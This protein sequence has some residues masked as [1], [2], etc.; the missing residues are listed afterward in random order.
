MVFPA[1]F[2]RQSAWLRVE[3]LHT[4]SCS[5]C[6]ILV[7]ICA[8]FRALNARDLNCPRQYLLSSY[9]TRSRHSAQYLHAA[10]CCAILVHICAELWALNARDLNRLRQYLLSSYLARSRHSAHLGGVK[11]GCVNFVVLIE[12][13]YS[14]PIT[15]G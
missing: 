2:A 15:K 13:I 1:W 9:L 8:E 7:R 6:A 5:C 14:L 4:A 11:P 12:P 10:S 3:Y